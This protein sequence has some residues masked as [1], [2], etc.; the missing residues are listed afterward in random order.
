LYLFILRIMSKKYLY[1]VTWTIYLLFFPNN[2]LSFKEIIV[3]S[4]KEKYIDLLTR[5]FQ[6]KKEEK[7]WIMWYKVSLNSYINLRMFESEVVKEMDEF[8]NS[9]NHKHTRTL[10]LHN[11]YAWEIVLD[12][13]LEIWY[14]FL[15]FNHTC[16]KVIYKKLK[17]F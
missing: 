14:F 12:L 11:F 13:K 9:I 7:W 5:G 1:C 10:I 8:L 15:L 4:N 3:F 2:L 6:T 17:L 16:I